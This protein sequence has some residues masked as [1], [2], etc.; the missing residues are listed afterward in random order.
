MSELT[1]RFIGPPQIES[2]RAPVT[3]TRRKGIALLAYLAVTELPQSRDT[4]ANL[5]WPG[6]D[7]SSARGNLR[8]TL[9]AVQ[10]TIGGNILSV[11]RNEISL[12]STHKAWFDVQAFKRALG[13]RDLTSLTNDSLMTALRLYRGDFLQ[14]FSVDDSPEF[15]AWQRQEAEILRAE[16]AAG[17]EAL[18]AKLYAHRDYGEAITVA[19]HCLIFLPGHE[20]AHRALMELYAL[21]GH[22]SEALRQ[23]ARCREMLRSELDVEPS[24]LTRD[25]YERIRSDQLTAQPESYEQ[26]ILSESPS[27]EAIVAQL[28]QPH[29]TIPTLPT[30]FV[31][32]DEELHAIK[33]RLQDPT[34]RLLVLL[35]PGGMGKTY[36]A[37]QAAQDFAVDNTFFPDG[38]YW[39]DLVGY[40]TPDAVPSAIAD[41]LGMR[42]RRDTGEVTQLVTYL[43]GKSL[44]LILDNFEHLI[45]AADLVATIMTGAANCK[46]LV[47]S[48]VALQVH[49][50]WLF[51]IGG[52]LYPDTTGSLTQPGDGGL[53]EYGAVRLF[54]EAG[55]RHLNNFRL[56]DHTAAIVRICQLVDGMPLALELAAT[57]LR[58]MSCE[59]IAARLEE[60]VG[61]LSTRERGVPLRHASIQAVFD[62]SWNLLSP[63]QGR[64]LARLSVLHG[65]FG[66][67]AAKAVGAVSHIE[68]EELIDHSFLRWSESEGAYTIH[69]LLRQFAANKLAED[70]DLMYASHK[71]HAE[72][73]ARFLEQRKASMAGA[74]QETAL[75]EINARKDNIRAAWRWSAN[76]H[77]LPTLATMLA[78]LFDF[79]I[80]RS[81][82]QE[83]VR[84]AQEALASHISDDAD[85]RFTAQLFNRDA[86]C[87]FYLGEQERSRQ[88]ASAA[89]E[90]ARRAGALT[91]EAYALRILGMNAYVVDDFDTADDYLAQA[92]Q[93]NQRAGD[94]AGAAITLYEMGVK[95]LL[96]GSPETARERFQ[97]SLDISR[98]LQRLDWIAYAL[99]LLAFINFNLGNFE[100]SALYFEEALRLF[101]ALGDRRGIGKT[102]GGAE[103]ARLYLGV[104]T[105]RSVV[106]A[107]ELA[108]ELFQ[109][110][111]D[112]REEMGRLEILAHVMLHDA[113]DVVAARGHVD[114]ALEISRHWYDSLDHARV[115]LVA[116]VVAVFENDDDRA[117]RDIMDSLRLFYK[118]N[119]PGIG[120]ALGHLA[121]L[122][123]KGTDFDADSGRSSMDCQA[124]AVAWLTAVR[125]H[126][127][128]YF[129]HD[130]RDWVDPF[131]DSLESQMPAPIFAQA[132]A[133][134]RTLQIE[135]TARRIIEQ[136]EKS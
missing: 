134:G 107:G 130:M 47:T 129:W 84:A 5:L 62:H 118:A 136:V 51:S 73:Y 92:L 11:T 33:Q 18:I 97:Q 44:L 43:A 3:L 37:I 26:G 36:L 94:E 96:F 12:P 99:D 124:D 71:A 68:L 82:F 109:A 76:N 67:A 100:R 54:Y 125:L 1:F 58:S 59:G 55:R 80:I 60:N 24:P 88:S 45:D 30:A 95:A 112:Q 52:M 49:G 9:Y 63:E 19:Q 77:H 108:L 41:G 14:G 132:Q 78:P 119:S 48:R 85:D 104:E 110:I 27:I 65:R 91:E 120:Q 111:G 128:S 61:L 29:V 66:F 75:N 46:L 98:R 116:G 121:L 22:R 8:R 20:S 17:S 74:E 103:R 42:F 115:L 13:R 123:A 89:L 113:N 72:H 102:I 53:D 25:L 83:G 87:R 56:Q 34:C 127:P 32:R 50:E 81:L 23:Y 126:S 70:P 90:L 105:V 117:R 114:R 35:G 15:D 28:A 106:L 86:I 101:Q 38:I 4:L 135:E 133:K 122:L 131:L 10:S 21:S 7:Q 57:W 79:Y 39:I 69:E 2:D 16:F 40:S 31:P 64:T 6:Y 93:A